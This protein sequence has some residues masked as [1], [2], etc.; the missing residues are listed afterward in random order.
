MPAI[1]SPILLLSRCAIPLHF[2]DLSP[3]LFV[4]VRLL[5]SKPGLPTLRAVFWLRASRRHPFLLSPLPYK[6]VSI[7]HSQRIRIMHLGPS[8]VSGPSLILH[9][10]T[11]FSASSPFSLPLFPSNSQARRPSHLHY[12]PAGTSMT[13]VRDQC[14]MPSLV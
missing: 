13:L 14:L 1:D 11:V 4:S 3:P 7:T 2:S 10:V 9:S 12:W 5:G 8:C 6:S